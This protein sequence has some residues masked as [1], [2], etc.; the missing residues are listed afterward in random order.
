MAKVRG[1]FEQVAG[2]GIWWVQYFASG[3]RHREKAGRKSDAIKLYQ[4]RKAEGHAGI[5]L[6]AKVRGTLLLELVDDALMFVSDHK[7]LTSYKSKAW[8]IK[9]DLGLRL[10]ESITPLDL[11][12]WLKSH[13]GW[14]PATA[15]RY[16]SFFSLCYREGLNNGKVSVNPA[17]LVRP[18][19][20]PQ[21]R[22]RFLSRAEYVE[23]QAIISGRYP[24]HLAEFVVSVHTGMRMGEQYRVTWKA[25]NE[26]RRTIELKDTKNGSPRTV[27]LNQIAL[28]AIESVRPKQPTGADRV[29]P[30]H[31]ARG[32][33]S[34][35]DPCVKAAGI[36]D[37]T[38]HG[39]RHT[40]CSWLAMAGASIREIQ[41][42]AGHKT[43]EMA[44]RYSH[45]SPEHT[46]AVVDRL[47][48]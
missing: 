44:A 16:R 48:R 34:W 17:K 24:Q 11:D 3:K 40:F 42:A 33:G 7:S 46:G 38:W 47:V 45:L 5:K 27:H 4:R 41:E 26:A 37:Y 21:G 25:V 9:Q 12:I 35:F 39:N 6:P 10:A 30:L 32:N 2:S 28:T 23:L 43:I 31:A 36:D 8:I 14:A 22:L 19:R 1:V 18:R 15:N 20:E 29:F 13:D